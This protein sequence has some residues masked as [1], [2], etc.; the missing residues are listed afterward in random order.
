[1][2]GIMYS[3]IKHNGSKVDYLFRQPTQLGSTLLTIDVYDS[4]GYYNA[5]KSDIQRISQQ[6]RERIIDTIDKYYP[7][8]LKVSY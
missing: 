5:S 2:V 8:V 4:D 6:T 1:M 3:V 7:E